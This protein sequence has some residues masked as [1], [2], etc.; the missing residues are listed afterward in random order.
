MKGIKPNCHHSSKIN[1]ETQKHI[2][3]KPVGIAGTKGGLSE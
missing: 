3:F 2:N 1:K